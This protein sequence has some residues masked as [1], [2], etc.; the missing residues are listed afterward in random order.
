[1]A[2]EATKIS[3]GRATEPRVSECVRKINSLYKIKTSFSKKSEN[4]VIY[5][6]NTN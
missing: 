3:V 5:E 4:Y 2:T 6:M 1:M